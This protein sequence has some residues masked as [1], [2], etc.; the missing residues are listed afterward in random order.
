MEEEHERGIDL[1]QGSRSQFAIARIDRLEAR[2][3]VVEKQKEEVERALKQRNVALE[4]TWK[5]LQGGLD[6]RKS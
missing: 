2:L 6:M 4:E 3:S 5:S 1:S